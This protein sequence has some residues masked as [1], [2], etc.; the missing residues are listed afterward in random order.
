ML[1]L[2]KGIQTDLDMSKCKDPA[3]TFQLL[4]ILEY[5]KVPLRRIIITEKLQ[6]QAN[7]MII[8]KAVMGEVKFMIN[9][10]QIKTE[11]LQHRI[12]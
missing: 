6:V 1:L 8:C 12:L 11:V 7:S 3:A 9:A 2:R 10:F 4:M 5:L